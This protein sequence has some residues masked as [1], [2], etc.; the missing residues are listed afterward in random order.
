MPPGPR[1][2]LGR[3]DVQVETVAGA[4]EP[5]DADGLGRYAR[6]DGP[7]G[8]AL[9]AGGNVYVA[10]SRNHRIRMVLPDGS[11][12]TL[13]GSSEGYTDG[14]A[15]D[16]RFRF[17]SGVAVDSDGVVYVADTGNHCIRKVFQGK[18]RTLAGGSRGFAAGNGTEARFDT[19]T[20]VA[21]LQ[22][23]PPVLLVADY[24]NR[25][26]RKVTLDG[27]AD[28][29]VPCPGPPLRVTG[30]LTWEAAL[31]DAG[32]LFGPASPPA[33]IA[34]AVEGI[35]LRHPSISVLVSA[36]E[37][38]PVRLVADAE[39]GAVLLVR[40]ETAQVLAGG[41]QEPGNMLAWKDFSGERA[42]FGRIGGMAMDPLGRVYVADT[43]ANSIRRLYVPELM[44]RKDGSR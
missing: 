25:R 19:P 34:T 21:L 42:R 35:R 1:L 4:P 18:V 7:M 39:Q 14:P 3:S 40:D 8:I 15:E 12:D 2:E 24:G 27:A 32:M 38:R 31:P 11:V 9:D 13:A 26:I 28:S 23:S 36:G 20:D 16:A 6:F 43:D 44:H 5:G 41:C 33:A 17:P 22:G 29:G 10:D 37:A 30:G